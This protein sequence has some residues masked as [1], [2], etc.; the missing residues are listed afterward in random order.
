MD[1]GNG[2]RCSD[3]CEQPRNAEFDDKLDELRRQENILSTQYSQ[4]QASYDLSVKGF[5]GL[6]WGWFGT[7]NSR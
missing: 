2:Y 4:A 5:G 3:R 6:L 7:G 1:A